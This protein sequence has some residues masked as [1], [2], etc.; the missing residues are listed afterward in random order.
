MGSGS[1]VPTAGLALDTE[2]TAPFTD[3]TRDSDTL[4]PPVMVETPEA[5]ASLLDDLEGV[6]ELGV[7]TEADSFYSYTEKVCLLQLTVGQTDYLVDPLAGLDLSPLGEIF[8]DESVV[9]ILHDGEFDVL[10]LG[11]DFN[12]RFK[13]IFD[14]RIAAAA[15][16]ID[17]PGLAAVLDRYFGVQVD[18][19][20]QRSDWSRRPL[21]QS[22]I[23]YARLDTRYLMALK[24]RM[25]ADLEESGRRMVLDGECERLEELEPPVREFDPDGYAK[26]KGGNRLSPAEKGVLR[27]LFILRNSVA[28]ERDVPPFKVLGNHVLMDLAVRMPST[29]GE[30]DGLKGFPKGRR[31]ALGRDVLSA[32]QRGRQ[33]P[34]NK[35][36]QPKTRT[37]RLD[38][39]PFEL[40]ERLRTWRR[41][42]SDKEGMDSSLVLNRHVMLRLAM[43]RPQS[44]EQIGQ[45]EGLRDW[46]LERFGDDLLHLAITFEEDLAAGRIDF[47][48]R[49]KRRN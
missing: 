8:G 5:L 36:V 11:R 33:N 23:E 24:Q 30:I 35:N 19:S 9:K 25:E 46:Q 37:P 26:I 18:K 47:D 20:E 38:D 42:R 29:M 49:K 22:Q 3:P 13:N 40:H 2:M 44:L 15:L 32:V 34:V 1:I 31:R 10:I 4:E 41:V 21:K 16:G 48:R 45:V 27:E 43:D 39:E 6:Q 17:S 14:T 12:F 28:E 7:D